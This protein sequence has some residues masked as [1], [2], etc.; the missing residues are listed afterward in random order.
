MVIIALIGI[1]LL[2]GSI[3]ETAAGQV[4]SPSTTAGNPSPIPTQA[5]LTLTV[6]AGNDLEGIRRLAL[7][8]TIISQKLSVDVTTYVV[9]PGDTVFAI[10]EKNNLKPSTILW[11][12]LLILADNP[13]SIIPGLRLNILPVD[14][15]YYQWNKSDNMTRVATFFGVK[16]E[17]ILNYPGNH[18][19]PESYPDPDHPPIPDKTWLII[20]GGHREFISWSAPQIPRSNPAVAKIYGAGY[21]GKIVEGVVGSGAFIWPTVDHWLS[22]Y[23]YN[24][25]ANHPAIDI[26]GQLGNAVYAADNGVVVYAGWNDWGYGNVIVIDHGN[27][28]QTLYAHLSNVRVG[29]GDSVIKGNVIGNVGSTGRSS[30]PHLHFEMSLDGSK[31]NPHQYLPPP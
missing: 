31:L 29:C 24:P 15:V 10:A 13:E 22:G 17:D 14:G 3:K 5:Q 28:W 21:C 2:G 8:H 16:P 7:L 6:F 27:G 1:F 11:G 9:Q 25:G 20:P 18:L 30:G 19:N 4:F 12:N 26:A 23:D